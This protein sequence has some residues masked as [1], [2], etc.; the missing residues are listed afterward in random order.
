MGSIAPDFEYFF[1]MRTGSVISHTLPGVLV[2]DVPVAVLL[3]FVFHGIVRDPLLNNLPRPLQ[4]RLRQ[5]WSLDFPWY[6][7]QH[8]S[9]FLV[10]AAL[11]ALSH[12]SWDALTHN[13]WAAQNL[14]VYRN[15]H[16]QLGDADYPLFYVL[17]QLSTVLGSAAVAW[18]VW[19]LPATEPTVIGEKRR[20]F[21]P[22]VVTVTS[23]VS[24][25]RLFGDFANAGLGDVVITLIASTLIGL[26]TTG[27]WLYR[28]QM[29][30]T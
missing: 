4:M 10:S 5:P 1:R 6:F 27:W 8:R 17:Q 9:R 28:R 18:F 26:I 13:G 21:W 12:L 2:F 22:M 14:S 23:G 11:G 29:A 7:R 15:W 3:A 30:D 25:V 20:S 24:A 19:R 16:L